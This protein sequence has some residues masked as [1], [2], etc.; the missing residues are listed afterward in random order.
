MKRME[1]Q[2]RLSRFTI[3]MLF[4]CACTAFAQSTITVSADQ[5]GKPVAKTMWGIFFEDINFGADGGLYAEL[6][7]NRSFEFDEPMMGWSPILSADSDGKTDIVVKQPFNENNPHCLRM[8]A[9][10]GQPFGIE[11]E[12]F[13][14]MGIRQGQSY[15]FSV[16]ARHIGP[17]AMSLKTKVVGAGAQSIMEGTIENIS[18][19]WKNYT[20]KMEANATDA[21]CK[22]NVFLGSFGSVDLDMV[23]LFPAETAQMKDRPIPGL[24]SDLVTIL[25]DLKPGFLRF[26]G[27]CIVEGMTLSNRYEWKNTIGDINERKTIINRW[28]KE[29]R[30]RLTPDYFQSYGLGFYEY[31]LLCEQIGAEPMPIINC[32]MACQFNTGQT[33][34]V[35]KLAPFVQDTLDLIE[36]A[37]GSADSQWGGVR[38]RMGHPEPFN[39]KM[40]GVG[41]EQW[42][43][44]YVER[45]KVFAKA[46]KEKYPQIQLIAATGSDPA[47]FP[48]G[49]NEVEYLWGEWRKLDPDI[50]DEHFYRPADWFFK[51]SARYDSYDRKGPKLFVGEYAAISGSVGSPQNKNNLGCALAEAA[52]M[53]GLERNADIVSMSSYAPLFAHVDAWQ[54][55]PDLIWF[56]NLNVFGTPNYYVQKLFSTNRGDSVLPTSILDQDKTLYASAVR[57]GKQIILKVVNASA[58]DVTTDIDLKGIQAVNYAGGL[59]LS[60]SPRDE[61]SLTEPTK[62]VPVK[63]EPYN[64]AGPKF[65]YL[66]K[67]YSM[68]VLQLEVE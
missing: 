57:A 59:V 68:T 34:A 60:G 48:N 3:T 27:G 15:W 16:Y 54:W 26:P 67:P 28:N 2:N 66:F 64:V 42:G 45:Y 4:T 5:P 43:P 39:M 9:S 35:D 13:R 21:K 10:R 46:L 7:K 65:T 33:V 47:I 61:N 49:P 14:G 31:F 20:C 17:G 63:A 51:N 36:F 29:F 41:N 37:N 52:F 6:V 11:N 50:V 19:D 58:E 22:L 53:I 23:S 55:T 38:A 12:G 24:R 32:G 1:F 44:Q 18:G 62:V 30:H 25:A 40:L 56:D 8:S